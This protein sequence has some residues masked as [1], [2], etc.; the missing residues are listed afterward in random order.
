M[1]RINL[2]DPAYLSNE[3]LGAEYRELPRIFNLVR[4]VQAKGLVPSDLKISTSYTLGTGHVRFFYN[5]LKWL[6]RRQQAII[7]ECLKRG[8]VVNFSDVEQLT[9][10]IEKHW[11]GEWSPSREE[12]KINIARINERGGLRKENE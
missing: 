12:I 7:Q 11:L 6:Q 1:T 9:V 10:G 2:V 4:A 5:K 3:H 8:R